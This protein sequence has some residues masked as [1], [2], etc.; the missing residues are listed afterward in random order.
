MSKMIQIRKA[1]VDAIDLIAQI[2]SETFLETY[3]IN[4]PKSDI[5]AFINKAFDRN[6]LAEELRN[7]NIHF[8][9]LY[10]EN[11]LAGYSKILLNMP[12]EN[13]ESQQITKLDRLY[14]RKE[15]HGQDLGST[16]FQH[17]VDFSKTQQQHG[18]WLY[19]WIE[20]K[21][22]INFYTK[23]NFKV[24]GYYDFV[25]SETRSNPNDVMYLEY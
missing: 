23:N 7:P 18:I 5:E 22:A 20:N 4:T 14:L 11:K 15:F 8:Y 24:V 10:V 16:L 21:R 25:L 9:L 17:V 19:V 2:G 3:L 6:S 12:N 13:V 1:S